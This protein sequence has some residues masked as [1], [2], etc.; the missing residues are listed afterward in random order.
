M[1]KSNLSR[2]EKF[3]NMKSVISTGI[4]LLS[5]ALPCFFVALELPA[6]R[7]GESEAHIEE[8]GLRKGDKVV[9]LGDSLTNQ[10]LGVVNGG[11]VHRLANALGRVHG[12]GFA[13]IIPLGYSGWHVPSWRETEKTTRTKSFRYDSCGKFWD[14]K[15]VLDSKADVLIVFLGMNDILHPVMKSDEES[16]KKWIGEYRDFVAT[17]RNRLSPRRILL[18]TISPLTTDPQSR[19]N[20][21]RRQVNERIRTL[22]REERCGIVEIDRALDPLNDEVRRNGRSRLVGDFV[23]PSWGVGHAA[24]AQAVAEALG[25]REAGKLLAQDVR[26][27][28][29]KVLDKADLFSVNQTAIVQSLIPDAKEFDYE[30]SWFLKPECGEADVSIEVPQNWRVIGTNTVSVVPFANEP[31]YFKGT[32]GYFTLRGSPVKEATQIR[33]AARTKNGELH[34]R[35]VKIPAPWRARNNFGEWRILSPS[36]DYSGWGNASA[37]DPFQSFFGFTNETLRVFRKVYVP[38][39][40]KAKL[41]FSIQGFSAR[42]DLAV[43]VNGS[44]VASFELRTGSKFPPPEPISIELNEGW[45]TIEIDCRHTRSQRQFVCELLSQDG[46]PMPDILYDWHL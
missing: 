41:R 21:V 26:S 35:T 19:K 9:V 22:A 27:E 37:V 45:N 12:D 23:H 6:A 17:L 46:K 8:L 13:S 33:L 38:G 34:R 18:C 32:R 4:K 16:Q 43:R 15:D 28:V 31:R 10:G 14:A 7:Y 25:E 24:I 11:Y 1:G 5:F 29:E 42:L 44:Q 39:K 40:R 30:I 36:W 2:E 3:M 20:V